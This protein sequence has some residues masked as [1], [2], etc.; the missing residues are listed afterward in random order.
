MAELDRTLYEGRLYRAGFT[1]IAGVDEA[2]RGPLAGPVVAAAVILPVG[3]YHPD[4]KDSKQLSPQ[5]RKALYE[6]IQSVAVAIGLGVVEPSVI[7]QVNVLKA[8]LMA[9]NE[10][11]YDLSVQPDY[12][13]IDGNGRLPC[14]LP[15]ETVVKGDNLSISIA[16]ASI[17]AKVSRDWI[18]EI[19]DRQYPYYHFSRNK[20]YG[21]KEH[22]AAIE[23]YG[24]SKIH[25]WTFCLKCLDNS[26]ELP[27]D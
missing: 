5:K 13:L 3:Y 12:L 7:D 27:F 10:A 4:I 2:G 25:R 18:M 22:R 6:E 14:P 17:I 26:Q 8:T 24:L 16:A 20:G 9:M 15:Q 23:K 19:Y 21:T 1:R 11:I